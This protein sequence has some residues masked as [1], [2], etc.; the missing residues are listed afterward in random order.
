MTAQLRKQGR[1]HGQ[2]Q[3]R[4]GGQGRKCAFSHFPTR[5]SRTDGRTNGRTDQ[6]MDGPTDQ[7][8]DKASYRV[9]CPQLKIV[10]AAWPDSINAMEECD[11]YYCEVV[12]ASFIVTSFSVIIS[13]PVIINHIVILVY[14]C[15]VNHIFS[16]SLHCMRYHWGPCIG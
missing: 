5:S 15:I 6:R 1:I 2:Y 7:R 12:I 8:T 13:V 11:K 10:K 16:F 3:L 14:R 4:T 9:A